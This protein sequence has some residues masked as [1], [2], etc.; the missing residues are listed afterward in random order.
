M[1]KPS[2]SGV[3]ISE[4]VIIRPVGSFCGS[5]DA[6]A[7]SAAGLLTSSPAAALRAASACFRNSL[8]F[9]FR[10]ASSDMARLALALSLAIFNSV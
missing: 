4:S 10:R 2:G 3:P 6:E 7:R 5:V 9:L 1:L 8:S